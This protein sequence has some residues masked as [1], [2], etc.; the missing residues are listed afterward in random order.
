MKSAG[1]MV[2]YLMSMLVKKPDTVDYPSQR[3]KVADRFRGA[4]KFEKEKCIGCKMC[5]RVCP[6][7][8]IQIEKVADKEF[9]AIVRMDKCIFCGQCTD[10]CPK[11][12]LEN[13]EYFELA[14]LDKES[15]KK[16]I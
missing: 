6:A 10:S 3:A 8:A 16:E 2:P 1:R 15:L 11:K 14:T 13:T 4:L 12:A 9:K 7:N 5:E